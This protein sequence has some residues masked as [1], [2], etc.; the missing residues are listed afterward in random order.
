MSDDVRIPIIEE[1]AQVFKRAGATEHVRVQT[2]TVSE[3]LLVHES[4]LREHF[5]VTRVPVDREVDEAPEIRV[6]GELTIVPVIEERL[7]IEKR[8]FVV[9]ELHLR[10]SVTSRQVE[11]PVTLRRIEVDVDRRTINNQEEI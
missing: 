8:L 10:R 9:E 7:V 11:L 1:Q 4:V 6:E 2:R 3:D 5:E